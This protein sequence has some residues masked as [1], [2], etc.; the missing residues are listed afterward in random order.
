MNGNGITLKPT[1]H[2]KIL[3]CAY[4]KTKWLHHINHDTQWVALA[5][6]RLMT[7]EG[8][9]PCITRTITK[10]RVTLWNKITQNQIKSA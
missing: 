6:D 1:F 10:T 7:I 3:L 4:F 8:Q 5:S 9:Q 2:S